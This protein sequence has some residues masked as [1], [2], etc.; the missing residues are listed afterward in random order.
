MTQAELGKIV[1]RTEAGIKNIE[2]GEMKLVNLAFIDKLVSALQIEDKIEYHDDYIEFI[3]NNPATQIQAYRKRK[4]ITIAKFS[5][6][7]NTERSVVRKWEQGKTVLSRASYE[8]LME[9]FNE[10]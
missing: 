9:L 10:G 6:L 5:K 4:N 8:K 3:K 1:G 2:N 7:L